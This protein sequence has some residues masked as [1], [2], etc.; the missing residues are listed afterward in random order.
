MPSTRRQFLQAAAATGVAASQTY[1]AN[2]RIQIAT[3]GVGGMGSGDTEYALSIPG[4][5]LVAVSDVYDGRLARAREVWGKDLFTTRDHREVLTRNDVDAVIVATPDHWHT[6]IT[7]DAMEAGKDVF[8]E[9][10]MAGLRQR[11]HRALRPGEG[12]DSRGLT[13]PLAIATGR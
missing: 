7:I 3:I 8:V 12:G 9:K 5:E 10:P 13:S 2:D 1:A 11:S 6:E 4:V